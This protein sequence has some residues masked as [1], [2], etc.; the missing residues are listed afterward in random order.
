[1]RARRGAGLSP[2]RTAFQNAAALARFAAVFAGDRTLP[3][4][5]L[6]VAWFM[7]ES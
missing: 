5:R 6:K 3:P 7:A 2:V 4:F 1:V